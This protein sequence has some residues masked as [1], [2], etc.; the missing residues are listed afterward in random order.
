MAKPT[1][2]YH[3]PVFVVQEFEH[4]SARSSALGFLTNLATLLSARVVVSS[5]VLTG[6]ELASE[7]IFA[8]TGRIFSLGPLG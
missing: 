8:V 4:S 7:L 3:L 1:Q 6:K 2:V 5:K